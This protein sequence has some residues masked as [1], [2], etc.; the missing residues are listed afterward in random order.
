[1]Q[2]PQH[3]YQEK[4]R[5]PRITIETRV[6]FSIYDDYDDTYYSGVTQDIC[7]CGIDITTE[8]ALKIGNNLKIVLSESI[9]SLFVAEGTVVGCKFDNK[10]PN[11]FHVSIEFSEIQQSWIQAITDSRVLLAKKYG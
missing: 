3:D 11:I 5:S 7:A 10:D 1:M 2:M 6:S 9:G 4:P 8:H